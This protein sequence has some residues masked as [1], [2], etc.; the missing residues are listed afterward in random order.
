MGDDVKDNGLVHRNIPRWV[1]RKTEME[2]G[3]KVYTGKVHKVSLK[4][5]MLLKAVSE[6]RDELKDLNIWLT[7]CGYDFCQHLASR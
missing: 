4:V 5:A 2:V 1:R 6:E 3:V 7:R